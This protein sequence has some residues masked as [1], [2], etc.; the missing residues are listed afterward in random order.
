ML[1]RIRP[2][3]LLNRSL[4]VARTLSQNSESISGQ[5]M[6]SASFILFTFE[7]GMGGG[8]GSSV[9]SSTKKEPAAEGAGPSGEKAARPREVRVDA[10][11]GRLKAASSAIPRS[12][13]PGTHIEEGS[14]QCASIDLTA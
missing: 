5:N 3:G 12:A 1:E 9:S 11:E 8:D 7:L 6:P 13:T 14:R 4:A 2:Q 10:M